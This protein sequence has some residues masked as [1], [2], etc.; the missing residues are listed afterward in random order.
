MAM[1]PDDAQ[2][3]L[4]TDALKRPPPRTTGAPSVFQ[5][6]PPKRAV[7]AP[8][9]R[10]LPVIPGPPPERA[11]QNPRSP[12]WAVWESMK[13]NEGREMTEAQAKAF[14]AWARQH[15]LKLS[16]RRIEGDRYGVWR[17]DSIRQGE[18]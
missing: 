9:P 8:D 18:R 11:C 2:V 5:Q 10:S 7:G 1:R 14:A 12:W 4:L 3:V 15:R 16:R 6:R 13:P 17:I